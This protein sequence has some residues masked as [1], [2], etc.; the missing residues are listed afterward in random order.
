VLRATKWR[1]VNWTG[2]IL[3]RNSFLK[4]VIDG[5]IERTRIGKRIK[6]TTGRP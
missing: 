1:K 5:K 6:D 3:C 2:H 4:H